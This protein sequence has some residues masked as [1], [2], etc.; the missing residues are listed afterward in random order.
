MTNEYILKTALRQSAVDLCCEPEDFLSSEPKVVISRASPDARKY[1]KLPFLLELASYGSN[2]VA[3]CSPELVGIAERY[4]A[5]PDFYHCFETPALH[6]LGDGLSR[7]GARVKYMAEYFLPDTAKLG[8]ALER[9]R[10]PYET[11]LLTQPDFEPLYLPEWSNALCKERSQLDMLGI[12]AY[13]RDRMVGFAACS[14]D[15]EDMWQ[16]GI[17]VL[18][19]Y[20]RRGLGSALTALLAREVERRGALPFYGTSMSHIAS[21]RVALRAGFVPAWTELYAE[22]VK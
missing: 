20:R 13:D 16:I 15:C 6:E 7:F 3:S 21:Q 8:E 17:D 19:A 1:L 2:I 4:I 18:P 22:P 9:S 14:A 5:R 10:C 11:R 12:A